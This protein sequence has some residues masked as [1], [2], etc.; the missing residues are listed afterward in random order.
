MRFRNRR[1][2]ETGTKHQVL[3]VVCVVSIMLLGVTEWPS[4][5][6]DAMQSRRWQELQASLPW[7]QAARNKVLAASLTEL[8]DRHSSDD[9]LYILLLLIN[10]F[11]AKVRTRLAPLDWQ[12]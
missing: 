11:V 4:M 10:A 1:A 3:W 12:W 9:L 5:V 7:T 6:A 2:S 8:W